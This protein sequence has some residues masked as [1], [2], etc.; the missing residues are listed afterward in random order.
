MV[1][2][3]GRY[4]GRGGGALINWGDVERLLS[5]LSP[6]LS[7]KILPEGAVKTEAGSLFKYFTD[8]TDKARAKQEKHKNCHH[9]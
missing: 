4:A 3:N 6:T 2:V 5:K 9:L 8:L 1:T 7:L